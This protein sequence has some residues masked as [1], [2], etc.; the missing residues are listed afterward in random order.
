[1]VTPVDMGLSSG[2]LWA[3]YN[4]DAENDLGFSISEYSY[5][6]SYV[7]WGNTDTHKPT[8]A[9]S[10]SPWSWGSTVTG[11]PY[12]SSRGAGLSEIDLADDVANKVC[13][14]RW[15]I[16]SKDNFEELLANVDFVD[17]QDN[18]L[19]GDDK[20]VYAFGVRVVIMKSRI[21]GAHL[22][23]PLCGAGNGSDLA[24][25]SSLGSYWSKTLDQESTSQGNRLYITGTSVIVNN[26]PRYL[27]LTIRPVITPV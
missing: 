4:V 9:N 1:M 2:V 14:G 25:K 3:P 17:M 24:S 18:I 7:S 5:A 12:G 22:V 13:G 27:G 20:R 16:P 10:F 26:G 23:F 19:N 21:N 6:A 8:G 15:S 11:Y